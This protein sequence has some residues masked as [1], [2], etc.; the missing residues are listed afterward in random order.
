MA[1]IDPTAASALAMSSSRWEADL[2]RQA[3]PACQPQ[4][5]SPANTF[6]SAERAQLQ[7]FLAQP[8]AIAGASNSQRKAPPHPAN[9][10]DI[11][12]PWT[13]L[14]PTGGSSCQ[15]TAEPSATG[16][17]TATDQPPLDW[18]GAPRVGGDAASTAQA[19]RQAVRRGDFTGPTNG[20]CPGFLQCNLVILPAGPDAF[21]FLL[22][23][24]R[25][26]Q[27]CPLLEVCD[28]GSPHPRALAADAD[29][30]TDCPKYVSFAVCLLV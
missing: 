25:N 20:V 27:A 2:L 18:Y 8:C 28:T 9:Q 26:P 12:E 4:E 29:V 30:R 10:M 6:T 23:C 1:S 22:F 17:A 14:E 13:A 16:A 21:D 11:L 19:F 7:P 3:L 15:T 5:G 24:Q